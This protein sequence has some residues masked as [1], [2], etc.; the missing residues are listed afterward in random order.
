MSN[1]QSFQHHEASIC[2]GRC[3]IEKGLKV[4]PHTPGTPAT[5]TPTR[6]LHPARS[7]GDFPY[8]EAPTASPAFMLT[9]K[10]WGNVTFL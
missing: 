5:P 10:F 4:Q 3:L 7:T 1:S 9:S 6:H 8:F 2:F